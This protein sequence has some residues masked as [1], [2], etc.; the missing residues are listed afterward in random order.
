MEDQLITFETAKLAKEKGFKISTYQAYNLT[1]EIGNLYDIVGE[2]PFEDF[3]DDNIDYN[4][5]RYNCPSQSLLQRWL[6]EDHSIFV[7]VIPIFNVNE[8]MDISV[9]LLSWKFP[10]IEVDCVTYD[11]Y[12]GLEIGLQQG[13]KL[14]KI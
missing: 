12:E 3:E 8:S 14:I 4:K 7:T 11:L 10:P 5:L 9:R 13:L 1:G 2:S 6:Y